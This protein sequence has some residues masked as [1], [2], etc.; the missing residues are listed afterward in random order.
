ANTRKRIPVRN[1]TP[2]SSCLSTQ[3]RDR[4]RTSRRCAR[5]PT[6]GICHCEGDEEC[7][8]ITP[9]RCTGSL[10]FVHQGCLHQWIKS[11][12]T[13]C[14]ELCKYAFIME[15]HLKPLRKWEKLQM[16]T[17]ER[18][19]IFCSVTF[20][21]AAVVCVIWSLYVLIDR[22]TEEIRQGKNNGKHTDKN[23]QKSVRAINQ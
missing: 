11:S 22:T 6:P 1:G 5:V 17:S 18:R 15:T 21:L 13:R 10:R 20:H 3:T 14:C 9:C 23:M 12:D 7:A 19:K 4:R 8:L 2:L 16:S